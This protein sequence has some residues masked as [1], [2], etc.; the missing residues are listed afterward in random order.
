M[1]RRL[2]SG[3][4]RD[5]AFSIALA[6]AETLADRELTAFDLGGGAAGTAQLYA[7][8]VRLNVNA[9]VNVERARARLRH[10]A[11]A[12]A[13]RPMEPSLLSGFTGIAWALQHC[14]SLLDEDCSAGLDE[15]DGELMRQLREE[16]WGGRLDV[17]EGLAGLGVYAAERAHGPLMAVIASRLREEAVCLSTGVAWKTGARHASPQWAQGF[18]DGYYDLGVAHGVA[19][20]LGALVGLQENGNEQPPGI[21]AG[22]ALWL[23]SMERDDAAMSTFPDIVGADLSNTRNCFTG[24]CYGGA[25][26]LMMLARSSDRLSG[27]IPDLKAR[28]SS[29]VLRLIQHDPG[30]YSITDASLCHGEAGLALIFTRLYDL[31]GLTECLEAARIWL[32]RVVARATEGIDALCFGNKSELLND[33]GLL[34]GA[35]GV[36]L[37]LLAACSDRPPSW[38]RCLLLS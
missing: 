19:G 24:W 20:I 16:R 7:G 30:R 3:S 10:A 34:T 12:F 9:E 1:W 4:E 29:A 35:A 25:G 26:I 28:V 38:D 8:L 22:A 6:I 23:L 32:R 18:P 5:V 37:C 13:E 14:R 31:L 15:L 21:M 11:R 2:L 33:G 27:E 36:A 17:G